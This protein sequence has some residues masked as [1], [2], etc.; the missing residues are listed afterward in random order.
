VSDASG[1]VNGHDLIVD[2]GISA[3]RPA[4]VSLSE[5]KR[6]AEVL[7]ASDDPYRGAARVG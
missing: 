1:F 2:G 5:R 7:L 4:S 3:G 6:M